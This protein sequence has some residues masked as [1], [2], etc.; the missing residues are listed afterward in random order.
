[1]SRV[2]NGGVKVYKKNSVTPSKNSQN[3]KSMNRSS[4]GTFGVSRDSKARKSPMFLSK[5]EPG[6]VGE[7]RK[8]SKNHI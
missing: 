4:Y 3:N 5:K 1:M 6:R 2:S 8:L 7:Y